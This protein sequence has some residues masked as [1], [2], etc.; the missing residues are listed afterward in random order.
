MEPRLDNRPLW[1][2]LRPYVAALTPPVYPKSAYVAWRDQARTFGR[3]SC[4]AKLPPSGWIPN[5]LCIAVSTAKI[6]SDRLARAFPSDNNGLPIGY[7]GRRLYNQIGFER[8]KRDAIQAVAAAYIGD[9]WSWLRAE[10]WSGSS[11]ED[12][13]PIRR[14]RRATLK[15]HR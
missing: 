9:R 13:P 1:L 8:R 15:S 4:T 12:E 5:H 14:G 11:S 2:L 7:R 6:E 10:Y 3:L